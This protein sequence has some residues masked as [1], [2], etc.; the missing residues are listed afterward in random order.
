MDAEVRAERAMLAELHGGCS[1]PVGA[2]AKASDETLSLHAQVTSLDG[3]KQVE[4]R[5]SGPVSEP[6]KLGL[7]VAGLLLGQGAEAILAQIRPAA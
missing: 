7:Q 1:V 4:A 6:E 3:T 2:Y 5:L